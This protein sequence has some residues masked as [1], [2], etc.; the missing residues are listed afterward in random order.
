MN[1]ALRQS[2]FWLHDR[3]PSEP[4]Y[5]SGEKH[6]DGPTEAARPIHD[7]PAYSGGLEDFLGEDGADKRVGVPSST[8]SDEEDDALPRRWFS[9]RKL[10]LFT[11]PGFLMSIAYLVCHW[12]S[13]LILSML[14][15]CAGLRDMARMLYFTNLRAVASSFRTTIPFVAKPAFFKAV[16]TYGLKYTTKLRRILATLNQICK[17]ERRRDICYAGSYFGAQCW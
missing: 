17:Q 11:G 2:S 8:G 5:S 4:P 13:R 16:R 7:T 1:T 10:W 6:H 9:W 3:D 12:S 15:C 14:M